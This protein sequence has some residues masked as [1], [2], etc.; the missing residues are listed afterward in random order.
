M[1]TD[2]QQVLDGLR[3]LLDAAADQRVLLRVI[4]EWAEARGAV[5]DPV[6]DRYSLLLP[7]EVVRRAR[8]LTD[9]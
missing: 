9:A 4:A 7:G 8:A 3:A 6:S 2:A 1:S 5:Y